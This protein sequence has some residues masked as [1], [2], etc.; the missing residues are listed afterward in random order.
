VRIAAILALA[1]SAAILGASPAAGQV[2]MA[3]EF[4]GSYSVHDLGTPPDVPTPF[5]GLTLKAG[6]TDRLLI[7]GAANDAAG[8]LYEVGVVRDGSGHIL[9]FSGP[10]TRFADAAFNDGGVTYGPDGVLFLARWPQNELGQTK[11][12]SAVTDKIIDMSVF[13]VAG[14]LASLQFVPA[15]QPGAGSLKLASY[16][17]GEWYDA[18]VKPDGTGTFD[19]TAVTPVPG[20]TLPGGPE[21][22]VYVAPGSPKFVGPSLLVAEYDAGQVTAYDVDAEGDPIV[23]TG[24]PF[25]TGIE[26]AEGSFLDPLTGDFLFSTFGGFDRVIVVRGFARAATLSVTTEVVNDDGGTLSPEDIDVHVRT[27]GEEVAGSPQPGSPVGSIYTLTADVEHAVEAEAV[28]R[29][30]LTYSRDC[31]PDGRVTPVEGVQKTCVVTAD[32]RERT[33]GLK[34]ITEVKGGVLRSEDFTVHVTERGADVLGSPQPGD[35]GGRDFLLYSGTYTVS[36]E[37]ARGYETTI[38]GDCSANGIVS[39]EDGDF[40]TCT[41]ANVAV[42][43]GDGL[44][45]EGYGPNRTDGDWGM[46]ESLLTETRGHLQD[47]A[48]FGPEGIVGRAV[49]IGPGIAVANERTL[50]GVDVFFTGWVPTGSYTGEEKAALRDFVVDGGTLI[51][52]TDDSGHTMVDLFGLVQ[53]DGEGD[54]TP[55]TISDTKH[56]I[57]NGP[58]G[59]VTVFNQYQF[60]GHYSALG[61]F[62]REIGRNDQGT[63]LAVI[64][65]GVLGTGSG[66]AIFVADVDVFSNWGAAFNA[67]LI[68]NVFAFAAGEGAQPSLTIGDV[69]AAE[70]SSGGAAL[71]FTVTLSAASSR[72]V[73][74]RYATADGSA[75]SPS[76]YVAAT[77]ILE[78]LPGETSK[79]ISVTV[80][81]DTSVEPDERFTVNLSGASGARRAD[82]QGVGTIANDDVAA[83]GSGPAQQPAQARSQELPPPEAGVEVNALPKSGTVRVKVRGS[84]RFV[85]LEE[86]QQIP[87]GTVVDTTKGRVTI[88]AAG[89]QSA[90]FYDGIFRLSQTNGAKPL[91]TLTLVEALSCPKGGKAIAAA[92]K[93]KRRLWGDGSG[94]FQTKGTHSAATVVGTKWLV[95]DRCGSTLTKVTRGKVSVRDF[96]KKKTVTVR[97]GKQYVARAK[98]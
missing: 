75:T 1:L 52:T 16:S 64:E 82:S 49:V 79:P 45:I 89:N 81:G 93:K 22:F 61:Q 18:A 15:G 78:F 68:K 55:N 50:A 11:P 77:G 70:G 53:G 31:A 5:G 88:V 4:D 3:P 59:A 80:N 46:A 36:E 62:A 74:V 83:Q 12:E 73:T 92:K 95:E 65:R 63:S 33:A 2:M 24:R 7:G 76:D 51:A 30:T 9:G 32:D 54:P 85:E 40:K 90:D 84:S 34:V 44:V 98:R 28:P 38:G 72:T 96:V 60:S 10:V 6:T 66:A 20:S 86:G 39:L 97:A 25:V 58:F 29:Y 13:D 57:A 43:L 71:T 17:G 69:I 8:A 91:T 19:L 67:T 94:K 42:P 26:G 23:T 41:I 35:E 27:D 14:S 48:N 21:G 87:V 47:P 56:P 37:A